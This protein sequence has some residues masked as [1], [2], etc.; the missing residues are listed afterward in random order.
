MVDLLLKL[1]P[2]AATSTVC[3][4][5]FGGFFQFNRWYVERFEK[6]KTYRENLLKGVLEELKRIS[7]WTQ[8]GYDNGSIPSPNWY[9]PFWKVNEFE[10][11]RIRE[12]NRSTK[13]GSV[14]DT[15]ATA[16]NELEEGIETFQALLANHRNL[17]ESIS[18][19]WKVGILKK[20]EGEIQNRMSRPHS[21]TSSATD[22][23]HYFNPAEKVLSASGITL[24]DQ[25]VLRAVFSA[26]REIHVKGI[27]S[28]QTSDSLY[29]KRANAEE[30][31]EGLLPRIKTIRPPGWLLVGKFGS[32][33]FLVI[34]VMLLGG[35][36]WG[37]VS[38]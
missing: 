23:F 6:N 8:P 17:V 9:N 14:E 31:V 18:N 38:N 1:A 36:I 29:S 27:G 11:S 24:P 12:Y 35:F 21:Q 3:L 16:L 26:N 7:A 33:I 5:L 10:W 20:L 22:L 25:E 37:L 19:E 15:T 30:Q 32:R 28:E 34:G 4:A 13:I 2:L